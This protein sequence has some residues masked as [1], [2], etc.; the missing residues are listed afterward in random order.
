GKEN[1]ETPDPGTRTAGFLWVPLASTMGKTGGTVFSA[2][3]GLVDGELRNEPKTSRK[4]GRYQAADMGSRG[5]EE[6]WAHG[7]GLE[8]Q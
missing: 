6:A 1:I 7:G 3:W 2:P 8:E 4:N 5:F